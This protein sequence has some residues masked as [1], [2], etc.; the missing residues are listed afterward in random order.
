MF[1][2]ETLCCRIIE[3]ELY[4]KLKSEGVHFPGSTKHGSVGDIT[5]CVCLL[6]M[7]CGSLC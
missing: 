5:D 1:F 2:V 4:R 3:H 7:S 6:S